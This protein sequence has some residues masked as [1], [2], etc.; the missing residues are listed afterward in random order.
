MK[1]FQKTASTSELA[2]YRVLNQIAPS[3]NKSFSVLFLPQALE[4]DETSNLLTLPYY[5]GELFNGKWDESN[6]GSPLD[7]DLSQE[8][9]LMLKDLAQIDISHVISNDVLSKTPKVTFDYD[10]SLRHYETLSAK[11][12]DA[13]LIAEEGR[14]QIRDILTYRQTTKMIVSNGDFYPR[15]FIRRSDGRIILIDWETWCDNSPWYIVDH[16]ENVAAIQF[17][18]MWGNANWQQAYLLELRKLFDFQTESLNKAI[19]MKSLELAQ[20]FRR[21]N[22]LEPMM[23]QIK[24]LQDTLRAIGADK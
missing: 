19:V 20:I 8:I 4:I 24:L 2:I 14:R 1:T 21:T 23:H 9:P 13:G 10:E 22:Q 11:F 12:K 17:V 7:L 3:Y 18:H 5:G 16:P 6:G 15:N